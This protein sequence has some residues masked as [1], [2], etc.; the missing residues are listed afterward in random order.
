[1][2]FGGIIVCPLDLQRGAKKIA[3]SENIFV[4]TLTPESTK[5]DFDNGNLSSSEDPKEAWAKR[6]P[7]YFPVNVNRADRFA[8]AYTGLR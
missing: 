1:M 7:K 8:Y 2:F 3:K 6:H 4:I 5:G